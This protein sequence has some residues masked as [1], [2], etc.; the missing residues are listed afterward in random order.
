M[1]E[2]PINLNFDEIIIFLEYLSF[3]GFDKNKALIKKI[4]NQIHI[5]LKA[6][7]LFWDRIHYFMEKLTT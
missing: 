4:I 5:P 6:N 1:R 7:E 3:D 2:I